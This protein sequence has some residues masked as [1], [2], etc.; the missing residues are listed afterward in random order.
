MVTWVLFTRI[1]AMK[2]LK[3]HPQKAQNTSDLT[4]LLPQDVVRVSNNYN[5]LFEQPILFY[6]ICIIIALLNHVDNIHIWSAWIYVAIRIIHS[7]VQATKDIVLIRFKL[8][9]ISW[10]PL[11]IMVIREALNIF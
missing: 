9:V 3:I 10:I 5:H 8:F 11:M 6:A 7:I 4:K 2:R 1:P